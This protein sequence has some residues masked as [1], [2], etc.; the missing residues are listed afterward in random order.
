[1]FKQLIC[2]AVMA[3]SLHVRPLCLRQDPS[4]SERHNTGSVAL[5]PSQNHSTHMGEDKRLAW[6]TSFQLF[7]QPSPQPR[8]WRVC[9]LPPLLYSTSHWQKAMFRIPQMWVQCGKA[10]RGVISCHSVLS[11]DFVFLLLSQCQRNKV[12]LGA[13]KS[14]W[15]NGCYSNFIATIKEQTIQ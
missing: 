14:F 9:S 13:N 11:L 15:E 2:Q 7:L 4:G 6:P 1:M 10:E 3:L 12:R 8:P 5:A